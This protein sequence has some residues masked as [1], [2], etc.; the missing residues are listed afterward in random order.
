MVWNVHPL[1]MSCKDSPDN[2][3]TNLKER[4]NDQSDIRVILTNIVG[5]TAFMVETTND[6]IEF[7][8]SEDQG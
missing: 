1:L 5:H 8:R 2:A 7:F 4:F 6:V 3:I